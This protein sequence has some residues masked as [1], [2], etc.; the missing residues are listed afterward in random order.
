M[1]Y[2]LP[3]VLLLPGMCLAM[4]RLKKIDEEYYNASSCKVQTY[5]FLMVIFVVAHQVWFQMQK[6]RMQH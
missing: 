6:F 2:L 1:L 5:T 4:R 3:A